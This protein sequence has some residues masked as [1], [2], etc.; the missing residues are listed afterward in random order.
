MWEFYLVALV[1]FVEFYNHFLNIILGKELVLLLSVTVPCELVIDREVAD[2]V[3]KG[4]KVLAGHYLYGF[5][6]LAWI[7][8]L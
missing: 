3:D 8:L 4:D 1:I 5:V 6:F 2:F 7:V